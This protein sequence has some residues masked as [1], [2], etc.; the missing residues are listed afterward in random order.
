MS[1]LQHEDA[2]EQRKAWP[3]AVRRLQDGDSA[4]MSETTAQQRIAA[5]DELTRL[6]WSLARLDV[7][8]YP[9]EATPVQVVSLSERA[10]TRSK[11]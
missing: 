6:C 8:E 2:A 1:M 10:R 7:P 9:R 4:V 5:V 3:V 11:P